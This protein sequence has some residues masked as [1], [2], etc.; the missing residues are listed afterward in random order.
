MSLS[1][2]I[3]DAERS[4]RSQYTVA[5]MDVDGDKRPCEKVWTSNGYFGELKSDFV[6]HKQD[7]PENCLIYCNQAYVSSKD[8]EAIIYCD[9]IIL[10]QLLIMRNPPPEESDKLLT[11]YSPLY[12]S[13]QGRFLGIKECKAYVMIRGSK[14]KCFILTDLILKNLTCYTVTVSS[15]CQMYLREQLSIATIFSI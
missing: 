14:D 10:G 6:L 12:D 2:E 4:V 9:Y 13:E 1:R 8:G 7:F 5:S 11:L 15:L 3:T